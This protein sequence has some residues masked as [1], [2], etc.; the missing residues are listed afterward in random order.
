MEI[1][2]I[3]VIRNDSPLAKYEAARNALAVASSV[4]EVKDIKDKAEALRLYAQQSKDTEME[5]WF[6]EIKAR[7]YRRMGEISL[8]L[9]NA[10][11]QY[12]LP[13]TGQSKN[14]TLKKAGISTSVANR[15]EQI[16]KIPEP[17]FEEYLNRSAE[18]IKIAAL[19]NAAK[20]HKKKTKSEQRK[21]E[22]RETCT[23]TD[24]NHLVDKGI[25]YGCIYA[26]PPWLYGN[27][28]TRASTGNHYEGMTIDELCELPISD[29]AAEQSH[30]HLW[31]T[32]G[33]LEDSFKVLRAWG[34]EYKSCFVWVKPQMGIGNYWRVSHEFMLLGVKGGITFDDHSL[35]S[36]FQGKRNKHS[37]KPE[38]VRDMIV[39]A[40]PGPY[41]EL[42][43]RRYVEGWTI[44]GN[45]IDKDLFYQEVAA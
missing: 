33:F 42:F 9:D 27:Q 13:S 3:E 6:A 10:A 24:L 40:S 29:L 44:W 12:A 43:G 17:E 2:N 28:G 26:D 45:E 37:A 15:C 14:R 39:K 22:Q 20:A 19:D 36:W 38:E 25:K 34:F 7:A 18:P 21:V 41:L 16:A 31:T 8:S 30:L 35:M 23:V 11:N 4:D 1:A 5:R 32:N